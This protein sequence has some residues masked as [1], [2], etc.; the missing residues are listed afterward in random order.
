MVKI[1]PLQKCSAPLSFTHWVRLIFIKFQ[2]WIKLAFCLPSVCI[3]K[4]ERC[5][6][7]ITQW[8]LCCC[9]FK[10]IISDIF[11]ATGNF[12]TAFSSSFS[13]KPTFPLFRMTVY[14]HSP[15]STSVSN[16]D[17]TSSFIRQIEAKCLPHLQIHGIY[18]Q[19]FCC[20]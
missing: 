15:V 10:C 4:T 2:T 20:F 11:N 13:R 6:R 14:F 12:S 5:F 9:Y 18:T 1:F 8:S 19:F 3:G 17:L 7:K 16:D